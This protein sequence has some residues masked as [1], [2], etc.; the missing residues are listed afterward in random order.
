MFTS[1]IDKSWLSALLSDCL[2]SKYLV[3][4]PEY[5]SNDS[6][7]S[8]SPQTHLLEPLYGG[9]LSSSGRCVV[10]LS[11]TAWPFASEQIGRSWW[12]DE[13]ASW[14]GDSGSPKREIYKMIWWRKSHSPVIVNPETLGDDLLQKAKLI[15]S[16]MHRIQRQQGKR[17]C[18]DYFHK[19]YQIKVFMSFVKR[20]VT[21]TNNISW[22][23][24]LTFISHLL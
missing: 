19:S 7:Q 20:S 2:L 23:Y 15:N 14:R 21:A 9:N 5:F 13:L 1:S 12:W 17:I 22:T 16:R 3:L 18:L 6:L 24:S 10:S 8:R 4:P 11:S